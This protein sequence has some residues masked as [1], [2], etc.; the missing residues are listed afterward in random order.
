MREINNKGLSDG[1]GMGYLCL[2]LAVFCIILSIIFIILGYFVSFK[3]GDEQIHDGLGRFLDMEN[4]PAAMSFLPQWAGYVWFIIDC[5]VLLAMVV[6]IDILF[7]K[8]KNYF[9]GIKNVDF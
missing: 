8:S 4:I 9:T 7:V 5:I 3:G 2:V 1:K 6:I